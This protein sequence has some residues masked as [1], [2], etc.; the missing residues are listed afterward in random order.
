MPRTPIQGVAFLLGF[1]IALWLSPFVIGVAHGDAGESRWGDAEASLYA[2]VNAERERMH[3][4]PLL[5]DPDLD[6]VAHAHSAD[7]ARRGYLSHVSPEGLN[8]LDRI[9]AAGI[10]GFTLAAENAGLTERDD[11]TAEILRSWIAS[12]DHRRNLYAP[13]FN[14]TGL[15]IVRAGSGTWYVTQLYVTVP[16]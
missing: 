11:P 3:L 2:A 1:V 10:D 12:P 9:R 6:A 16:H 13:P 14:R 5:R 7:M 15:G 4:I 8:P